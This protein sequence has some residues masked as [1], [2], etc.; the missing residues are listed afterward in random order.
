MKMRGTRWREKK[1]ISRERIKMVSA[2]TEKK[3]QYYDSNGRRSWC[4]CQ[5]KGS[6]ARVRQE[7]A[8]PARGACPIK[9][10]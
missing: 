9:E 2:R 7:G 4:K 8:E 1:Y 6:G 3:K 5:Y 10:R